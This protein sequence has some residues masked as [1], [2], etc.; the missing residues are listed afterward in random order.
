MGNVSEGCRFGELSLE[1]MEKRPTKELMAR[2][3]QR[4][5]LHLKIF[6]DPF[7]VTVETLSEAHRLGMMTGDIE[8]AMFA[9][10]SA[11]GVR[12]Y[13]GEPLFSVSIIAKQYIDLCN[14]YGQ[15]MIGN[16]L[17]PIQQFCCNLMG[18]ASGNPL[19]LTGEAMDEKRLVREAR[20]EH[21]TGLQCTVLFFKYALATYL[22][23]LAYAESISDQIRLV[24]DGRHPFIPMV[25]TFHCFYEGLVS[26]ARAMAY[27]KPSVSRNREIR[28]AHQRLKSIREVARHCPE[29]MM[30]KVHLLQG[31][32]FA[33]SGKYDHAELEYRQSIVFA[34][35]EGFISEQALAC[36]KMARMLRDGCGKRDKAETYFLRA[37][38]L[39]NTYGATILVDKITK[40]LESCKSVAADECLDDTARRK[41]G[42]R[43]PFSPGCLVPMISES[44]LTM[45]R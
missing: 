1:I 13:T 17:R 21:N 22:N 40:E 31:D 23:E 20:A 26:A 12:C 19:I 43:V 9:A 39:Y 38:A 16:L 14:D 41:K 32:L 10:S 7:H 35:H 25:W 24:M 44:D 6:K 5:G 30:N 4:V 18:R 29:N 15:H 3:L 11:C 2:A 42:T 28:L 36:E 27:R 34:E 37:L 45:N 33:C 8:T